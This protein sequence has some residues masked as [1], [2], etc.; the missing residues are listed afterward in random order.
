MVFVHII[1][2]FYNVLAARGLEHFDR[3]MFLIAS[4]R[5]E[6]DPAGKV[7]ARTGDGSI[8]PMD[9]ETLTELEKGHFTHEWVHLIGK[10][11]LWENSKSPSIDRPRC[12]FLTICRPPHLQR[13]LDHE[14]RADCR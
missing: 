8:K 12:T 7:K 1:Q 3:Q 13:A 6:V 2:Y 10:E 4:G 9:A 11:S 5:A 14:L